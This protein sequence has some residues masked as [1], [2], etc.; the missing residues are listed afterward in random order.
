[1]VHDVGTLL[2]MQCVQQLY[3]G[4]WVSTSILR[5]TRY[6][7]GPSL[8]TYQNIVP[9]FGFVN[10]NCEL[11]DT[12]DVNIRLILTGQQGVRFQ[13]DMHNSCTTVMSSI[14]QL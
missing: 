6:E 4:C 3:L 12:P 7:Y 1:M 11:Q 5:G 14:L 10:L 8:N 13:V 9:L 2:F